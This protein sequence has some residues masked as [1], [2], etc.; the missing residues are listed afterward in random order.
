[1]GLGG[2][3]YNEIILQCYILEPV[4]D[5]TSNT[6]TKAE[7]HTDKQAIPVLSIPSYQMDSSPRQPSSSPVSSPVSGPAIPTPFSPNS[8]HSNINTTPG[9]A[10]TPTSRPSVRATLL[11]KQ[12]QQQ[13]VHSPSFIKDHGLERYSCHQLS[14]QS[15]QGLGQDST[16]SGNEDLDLEKYEIDSDLDEEEEGEDEE[17]AEEGDEEEEE[18]RE[19]EPCQ[20]EKSQDIVTP[21]RPIDSPRH[22]PRVRQVQQAIRGVGNGSIG[23]VEVD[24]VF[25]SA[26]V[27]GQFFT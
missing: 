26:C 14:P 18:Q 5:Q 21:G 1:M 27:S 3:A 19:Q 11:L 7:R 4:I 22:A 24:M 8:N 15:L 20:Q 13:A 9:S 2:L 17:G 25:V 16:N 10:L 6:L 12:I 23:R